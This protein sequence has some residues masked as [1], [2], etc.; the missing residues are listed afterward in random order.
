MYNVGRA[1]HKRGEICF[2]I[3]VWES[4]TRND[5]FD[6]TSFV[7]VLDFI[8]PAEIAY[9]EVVLECCAVE[10]VETMLCYSVGYALNR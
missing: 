6:R 3:E 7:T 9:N 4:R 2:P 10:R 8:G 5:V 1:T